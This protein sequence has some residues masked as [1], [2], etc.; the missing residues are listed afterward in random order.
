M[1]YYEIVRHGHGELIGTL[2]YW[3]EDTERIIL[4]YQGEMVEFQVIKF[5]PNA[6]PKP[7]VRVE[8]VGQ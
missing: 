3:N 5:D 4:P 6:M 7:M 1:R 2:K 8:P